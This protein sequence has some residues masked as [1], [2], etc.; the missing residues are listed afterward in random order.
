VQLSEADASEGAAAVWALFSK[1]QGKRN[2]GG[3]DDLGS[4]LVGCDD[5]E[6]VTRAKEHG[7][8]GRVSFSAF[9][10]GKSDVEGC[11]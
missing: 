1:L 2:E 10:R 3:F 6:V 7:R 4:R 8:F 11:A 5:E 9:S